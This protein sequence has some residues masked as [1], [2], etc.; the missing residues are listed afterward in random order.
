MPVDAR[1]R[2]G[3]LENQCSIFSAQEVIYLARILWRPSAHPDLARTLWNIK[4]KFQGQSR[5]E[6]GMGPEHVEFKVGWVDAD[7][8]ICCH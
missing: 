3:D 2:G 5:Q 4:Y 1:G 6:A 8:V 7:L